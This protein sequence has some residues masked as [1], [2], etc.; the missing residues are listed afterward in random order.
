MKDALGRTAWDDVFI[1]L[2]LD[3]N[4]PSCSSMSD[5]TNLL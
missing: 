5:R 4:S 1:Q 2:S 3:L